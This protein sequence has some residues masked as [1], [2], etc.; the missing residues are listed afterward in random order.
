MTGNVE[1]RDERVYDH[2]SGLVALF[3]SFLILANNIVGTGKMLITISLKYL[4][5]FKLK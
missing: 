4:R 1:R 5:I 3:F 2:Y